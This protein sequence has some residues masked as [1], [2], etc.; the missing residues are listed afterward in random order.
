[1]FIEFG[2]C[3][4]KLLIPL[5]YP[6][7]Y[8]IKKFGIQQ[9]ASFLYTVFMNIM[10]YFSAGLIY[11]IVLYRSKKKD[12]NEI[13]YNT[14]PNNSILSSF[15]LDNQIYFDRKN[16]KKKT[17]IKKKIIH[18]FFGFIKFCCSFI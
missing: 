15:Q 17:N 18:I 13:D 6:I 11:L 3:S 9:E 5:I 1:M 4:Y 2:L 8:Q 12:T 10:S 14:N 7:M 16:I